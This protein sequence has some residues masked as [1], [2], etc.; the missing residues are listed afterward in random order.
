ME[1]MKEEEGRPDKERDKMR[2]GK[3]KGCDEIG[4]GRGLGFVQGP[5]EE[6]LPK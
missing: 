2:Y 5:L 3:K 4:S 6:S 1:C